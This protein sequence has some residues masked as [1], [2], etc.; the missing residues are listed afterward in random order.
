[1]QDSSIHN[2]NNEGAVIIPR[3]LVLSQ[4]C[5]F[6]ASS[7]KAGFPLE[8]E[9]TIVESGGTRCFSNTQCG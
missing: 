5:D 4:S 6:I 2:Y 8:V 9:L 3:Q 7:G 1:M